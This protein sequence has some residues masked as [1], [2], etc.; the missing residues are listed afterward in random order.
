VTVEQL[1]TRHPMLLGN[2]KRNTLDQRLK[3]LLGHSEAGLQP[4]KARNS[5]F[6][7]LLLETPLEVK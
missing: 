2:T 6:T 7:D 4:R 3:R 5:S 1:Q